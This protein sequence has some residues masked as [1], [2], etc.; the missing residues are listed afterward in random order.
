M[1]KH[2]RGFNHLYKNP[3]FARFIKMDITERLTY[4]KIFLFWGP[5]A[6]TWLMMAFEQ[7]FLIA[8]IAR[9]NDANTIL[10]PLV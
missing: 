1:V 10:L 5:L 2:P 3:I 6:L 7:P 4:Q 9:L 8:F